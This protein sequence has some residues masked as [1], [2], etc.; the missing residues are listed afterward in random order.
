MKCPDCRAKL[1]DFETFWD[2]PECGYFK[3]KAKYIKLEEQNENFLEKLLG[4]NDIPEGCTACDNPTYP[5]C[6]YSCPMFDD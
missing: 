1:N 5:D 4:N 2:C 6:Q 3:V